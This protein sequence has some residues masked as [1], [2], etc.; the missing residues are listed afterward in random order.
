MKIK[1]EIDI[2]TNIFCALSL[3]RSEDCYRHSSTTAKFEREIC[4][5]FVSRSRNIG[6]WVRTVVPIRMAHSTTRNIAISR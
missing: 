4:R 3:S 5:E 1:V 2:E 6:G